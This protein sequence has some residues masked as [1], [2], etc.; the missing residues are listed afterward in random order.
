MEITSSRVVGVT[1][2]DVLDYLRSRGFTAE[3][4]KNAETVPHGGSCLTMDPNQIVVRVHINI[5]KECP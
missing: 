1:R 5:T 4:L 2:K 3:E